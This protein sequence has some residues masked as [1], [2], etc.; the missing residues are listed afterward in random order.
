[1]NIMAMGPTF[2]YCNMIDF[3]TMTAFWTRGKTDGAWN[4]PDM[5]TPVGATSIYGAM[6]G[7]SPIE[8]CN[9]LG[10]ATWMAAPGYMG[11]LTDYSGDTITA[12]KLASQFVTECPRPG[13]PACP[14]GTKEAGT[15]SDAVEIRG[16]TL[17][18]TQAFIA[19]NPYLGAQAAEVRRALRRPRR[20]AHPRAPPLP[21][22]QEF[23]HEYCCTEEHHSRRLLF[24]SQPRPGRPK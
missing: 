16:G 19:E 22:S 9:R 4:G 24:G 14:E 2:Q 7:E 1:M 3:S 15:C 8:A 20:A 13:G 21:P 11:Q 18:G 17:A 5:E 10:T 23:G 6:A 12:T